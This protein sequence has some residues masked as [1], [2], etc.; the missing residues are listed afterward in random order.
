MQMYRLEPI[1]LQSE[2]AFEFPL[3]FS[4]SMVAV[5]GGEKE[6]GRQREILFV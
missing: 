2:K 6:G 4:M 3:F 1:Y 5:R